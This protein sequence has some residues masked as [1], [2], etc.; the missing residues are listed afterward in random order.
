VV[1]VAEHCATK[2]FPIN[3][4][5]H[6][7]VFVLRSTLVMLESNGETLVVSMGGEWRRRGRRC[8]VARRKVPGKMALLGNRW[9]EGSGNKSSPCQFELQHS[10]FVLGLP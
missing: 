9:E 2:L 3:L 1:A 5:N 6:H 4:E 7:E 8:D 10:T